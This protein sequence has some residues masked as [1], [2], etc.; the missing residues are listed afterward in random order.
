MDPS[1][2]RAVLIVDDEEPILFAL[3]AYLGDAGFAVTCARSLA[4]ALA[5]ADRKSFGVVIADL[6]LH[7]PGG[8]EGLALIDHLRR[9]DA[10]TRV[11]LL[12]AYG[13]DEIREAARARGVDVFLHK[14]Q[15]LAELEAVVRRLLERPGAP[16]N[17]DTGEIEV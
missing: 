13:T 3:R 2:D 11:I 14:P 16:P 9:R 8:T 7:E 1:P 4:E 17:D 10:R 6:R 15:P 12:T 5:L